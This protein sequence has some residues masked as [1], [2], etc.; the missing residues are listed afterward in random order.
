M[1]ECSLNSQITKSHPPNHRH[2]NWKQEKQLKQR[3]N[4]MTSSLLSLPQ[5]ILRLIANYFK[6]VEDQDK[7]IFQF[8]L[9]WRNF[10]DTSKEYFKQWKKESQLIDL[11]SDYADKFYQSKTFR[12]NKIGC[13]SSSANKH[14]I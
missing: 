4:K 1:Y 6:T 9:D 11:S 8:P 12:K 10:L 3:E 7:Q 5:D 14:P 13:K 2:P